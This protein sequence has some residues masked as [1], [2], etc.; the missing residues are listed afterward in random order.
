MSP[1]LLE[2]R[3]HLRRREKARAGPWLAARVFLGRLRLDRALAGGADPSASPALALRAEQLQQPKARQRIARGL[4]RLTAITFE[5]PRRHVGPAMLPFRH[6]R[7]R[8]NLVLFEELAGALRSAGPHSVKGV[9]MASTLLE[10]GHGPLYA[11][12][13]AGNLGEALAATISELDAGNR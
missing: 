13:P 10:D 3:S 8:P 11:S 6:Q 1:A 7:V 12:D 5:D 2:E 9:A 4:E